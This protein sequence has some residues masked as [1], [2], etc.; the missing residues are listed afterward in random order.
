MPQ[1]ITCHRKA[2]HAL[3]ISLM[4]M[5]VLL[6]DAWATDDVQSNDAELNAKHAIAILNAKC[7]TCHGT[8]KAEGNLRL[9]ALEQMLQGGDHGTAVTPGKPRESLIIRSV[10]DPDEET[11]M[12][13]KFPLNTSEIETLEQWIAGGAKWPTALPLDHRL[14]AATGNAWEDTHNPIRKL[15]GGERLDLWSLRPIERP[16]IPQVSRP[17]WPVNP[18]DNF[19]LAKW[20]QQSRFELAPEAEQRTLAMRSAIDLTGLPPTYA[21]LDAFLDSSHPQTY[22]RWVERLLSEPSYGVRWA[23]LWLDVVRYSD[24]NGFDWDEFRPH[25][26][27]YRDYV[28][29]AW[30]RDLPFDQFTLE[31]LAGDELVGGMP[32]SE[33]ERQRLIATGYLRVGPQDNSSSLFNEQDRSR[34][35][36]LADLTET[37]GSAFMGL[38]LSCC[39][40]HDHKTD[41]LSQ[42]D[43]YRLRAF[44]SAVEFADDRP[45][46]LPERRKEIEQHNAELDRQI[47]ALDE[48]T[49]AIHKRA[50]ERLQSSSATVNVSEADVKKSLDESEKLQ[51]SALVSQ[52]GT[53]EK[54]KLAFTHGLLMRDKASD[55]PATYVLFQGD[56]K[57]PRERV[58]AGFPSVLEP[59]E[60]SI[61]PPSEGTTGRRLALAEWIVSRRNPWTARVLVN[62]LWQAHFGEGLVAT[63]NDLGVTG[64]QPSNLE[65]L[66]W[67]ASE[68]MDSGWSIKHVQRLIVTSRVYRQATVSGTA[69]TVNA[70]W[71]M[72]LRTKLR[73]LEAEVLRDRV[74][75]ASGLLDNRIGGPPVWPEI[76]AEILQA[77]PA[78]LDDNATKTKGWYPSPEDDQSVRSLFLVQKRTIRVPFMETFDLPDNSVSC[79]RR[80]SSLVAPQALTLLNGSQVEHASVALA[81]FMISLNSN[82]AQQVNAAFQHALLRTPSKAEAT[83]AE[84]F[85]QAHSLA[86]LCRVLMN[87]NEFAFVD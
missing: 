52:K 41:P 68:L 71:P 18:I 13:P 32:Q 72:T 31:Q 59:S 17:A 16:A 8:E 70:E 84:N 39:R 23:R 7:V 15:Y 20:D 47:A 2:V 69:D 78:F 51:V 62:R 29:D 28:I 21:E 1:F 9:D 58:E 11:R 35:E 80:E 43:H 40:C 5:G 63:P 48:Q 22:E 67:L 75:L 54:Q 55:V 60:A 73:R 50:K 74:L 77:N 65:L 46:D 87:T 24:S 85:L 34:A 30:N 64:A 4:I 61:A 57:T 44:F 53:L 36:L 33:D 38:T 79:A 26:W 83:A 56:H 27:K 76:P 82:A 45:I 49:A 86:E 81:K 37:T 66:D 6:R 25:A 14:A 42:A 10:R 12:P 19:V 3:V